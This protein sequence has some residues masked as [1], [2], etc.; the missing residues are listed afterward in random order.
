MTIFLHLELYKGWASKWNSGNFCVGA[1]IE[2][3]RTKK[4][5]SF[6]KEK[7]FSKI[8]QLNLNLK[9]AQNSTKNEFQSIRWKLSIFCYSSINFSGILT[10]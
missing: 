4:I 10:V 7:V 6:A 8:F 5:F 1:V 3:E 9:N 2:K